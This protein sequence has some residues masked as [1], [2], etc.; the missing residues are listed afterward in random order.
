MTKKV[1]LAGIGLVL[2]VGVGW[3]WRMLSVRSAEST[4]T[5]AA[6]GSGLAVE[7]N[8]RPPTPTELSKQS[9]ERAPA[10]ESSTP[11]D[12]G[13]APPDNSVAPGAKRAPSTLLHVRAAD[14]GQEL[15]GV[16][17][18]RGV[19][20]ASIGWSY[21]GPY[22]K[23]DV[24]A[25]SATSPISLDN[26]D[27]TTVGGVARPY[28]ARA[29]GYAWGR[30]DIELGLGT[31]HELLLPPGGSLSVELTGSMPPPDLAE[32][33]IR[34]ANS[35]HPGPDAIR[36]LDGST[37]FV[38]ESLAAGRQIVQV[39]I[40]H[41]DPATSKLGEG[42]VDI[43]AGATAHLTL[44]LRE[45]P[46][47]DEVP[48]EGIVIVPKEWGIDEFRLTAFPLG[49]TTPMPG[50]HV[51]PLESKSMRRVEGQPE[52]RAFSWPAVPVGS[53]ALDVLPPGWSMTVEV[54]PRGLTD[55]RVEVPPPALV[56]VRVLDVNL[57][58]DAPLQEIDWNS[59]RPEGANEGYQNTAG[60]NPST[61]RYEF[62][63]PIGDVDL[64]VADPAYLPLSRRVTV[65]PG[66]NEFTIEVQ[67]ACGIHLELKC[68]AVSV[69]F[70][71]SNV[72]IEQVGGPGRSNWNSAA[73]QGMRFAVTNPGRYRVEIH[74]PSGYRAIEPFPVDIEA[75][76]FVDVVAQV[77]RVP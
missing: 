14:T 38:L 35:T 16:E 23:R 17:V 1:A 55:A 45:I 54:G 70:D 51:P 42:E 73:P 72:S 28:F 20:L 47:R 5:T 62:S 43:V 64:T 8:A 6:V 50:D 15:T 41:S 21:P 39:A 59:I 10:T 75:G 36:T 76:K 71:D 65:G 57:G 67:Q 40:S 24:L 74:A 44:L 4:P 60:R 37:A 27:E 3:L 25:A 13:A 58:V 32:L 69:P 53:Y 52:A 63:A 77:E 31:E 68:G 2:L 18:V 66:R 19:L 29:R 34:A 49:A 12:T 48:L 30:I 7:G 11:S 9:E 61:K 26:P 46:H 56:S 22:V 33:L